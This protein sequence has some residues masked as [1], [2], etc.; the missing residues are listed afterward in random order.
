MGIH[1]VALDPQ[2]IGNRGGIDITTRLRFDG[3]LLEEHDD[4]LCDLL[5][6]P[7]AELQMLTHLHPSKLAATLSDLK[8]GDPG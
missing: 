8:G 4:P 1:P 7:G 2:L 5:D 6:R 3:F